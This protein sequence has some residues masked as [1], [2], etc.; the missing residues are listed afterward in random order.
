MPF[1]IIFPQVELILCISAIR[2]NEEYCP[3]MTLSARRCM[4]STYR[5]KE[6][7]PN[8][9]SSLSPVDVGLVALNAPIALWVRR[10]R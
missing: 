10:G 3:A 8:L 5:I 9:R 2:P 6:T 1:S 4:H 7:A